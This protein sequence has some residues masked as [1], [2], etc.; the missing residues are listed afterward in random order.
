MTFY[1]NGN[2][3]TYFDS[4]GVEFILQVIEKIIGNKSITAN[5]YRIYMN[6]SVMCTYSCSGFIDFML[7]GRSLLC[8]TILFSPY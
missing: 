4:F 3:V 7:K 6:D 2:N 5:I 1:V 8:Y